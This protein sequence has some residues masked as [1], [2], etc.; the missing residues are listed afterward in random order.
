[1]GTTHRIVT[2]SPF[3][4]CILMRNNNHG[5]HIVHR[6]SKSLTHLLQTG[7]S[8]HTTVSTI[9]RPYCSL[10][11]LSLERV[12]KDSKKLFTYL[13]TVNTHQNNSLQREIQS[14]GKNTVSIEFL[15]FHRNS[16]YTRINVTSAK[17]RLESH[18]T[19]HNINLNYPS[20]S[21]CCALLFG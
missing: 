13:V 18:Y 16:T 6:Q 20:S 9:G 3:Q 19:D 14:D 11:K 7:E 5:T 1:M 2:S 15:D 4:N 17:R 8:F 12:K 21:H 10:K